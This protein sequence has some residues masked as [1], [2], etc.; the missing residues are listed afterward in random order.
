MKKGFE[1]HEK[2]ERMCEEKN[3]SRFD[4]FD[5][6]REIEYLM[7]I[8]LEWKK[9]HPEDDKKEYAEELLK[10]LDYMHMVW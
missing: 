8:L 1:L 9:V 4:F 6:K 3:M 2:S 10:K 5:S 7:L